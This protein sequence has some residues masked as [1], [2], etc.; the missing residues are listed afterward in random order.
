MIMDFKIVLKKIFDLTMKYYE[1]KLM[2]I[3]KNDLSDEFLAYLNKMDE[4][5]MEEE[6]L[7]YILWKI[8]A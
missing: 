3:M 4:E 7:S 8:Q 1:K 6:I 5:I 2:L